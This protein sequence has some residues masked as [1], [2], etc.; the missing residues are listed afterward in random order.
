MNSLY[1][2]PQASSTLS[3]YGIREKSGEKA[4]SCKKYSVL[5][6]W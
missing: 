1:Q 3:M 6:V 4:K 2:V 5:K